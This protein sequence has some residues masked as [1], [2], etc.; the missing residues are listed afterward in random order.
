[1]LKLLAIGLVGIC[2]S[3][4]GIWLNHYLKKQDPTQHSEETIQ[5]AQIQ[6]KTEM[7]GIPVVIDSEVSGYLVFQISSTIDSSK[8]PSKDFDVSAYLLDA[9]IRASY[10]STEDGSLKFNALF[11]ERLGALVREEA[12]KKL[13]SDVVVAVNVQQFNFVPKTDVR[14]S[15]LAGSQN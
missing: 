8:L 1:M 3:L 4:G 7:T 14:G 15:V 10:K 2:A 12:N 13:A 5:A 11:L 6:L 9:A